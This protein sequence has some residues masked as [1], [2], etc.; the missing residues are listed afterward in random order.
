MYSYVK[1]MCQ[2]CPGCALAKPTCGKSSELIYNFPI[3][4]PFFI[5]FFV[6]YSAGK[7][8]SF[9]GFECYLIGCCGMSSFACMEPITRASAT[10][11]ASAIM[12]ILL[13][14]GFCHTIVLDKDSKFFGVCREAIDLLKN[15]CHILS[16]ANHN[17]MI[18]ERINR[19][20]TKG[21]KIMCN[22]RDSVR[23][24]LKAILL[25]LYAW[26]SCPVP[27][28]NIS[29]SLVAV[30]REFAF[31]INFS[32]GKHWEITSS[33]STIVLYSKELTTRQSACRQVAE[34]LVH[35]QRSYHCELINARRPDPCIYS[36]SNIVF[37]RH[38]VKSDAA[39]GHVDKLQYAFTGPW[40]I[41]AILPGASYELEHC[42]KPSKKEKKHASDLSP[43]PSELIPFQPVD[44]ADT[45]YGQLHKLISANPFK[46]G[47]IARFSPIQP[48]KVAKHILAQTD[49][50]TAFHWPS[51]SELNDDIALFPWAHDAE[52]EC[53]MSGDS[54]SKLP[55]LTTGPPPAAP[56]HSIPSI[57][58]IHLLTAAIIKSTDHLF[59]SL[60][61]SAPMT[62]GNGVFLGLLSMILSQF[63]LLA[64]WMDVS[65]LIFTS[66]IL[67][68]GTTMQSTS[69]I[70]SNST[71]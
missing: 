7:H 57:P 25:L 33:P 14:Y 9:E 40:H 3:E 65:F 52:Y 34:L 70:G 8:A 4:A 50:C 27:G 20:L 48:F 5:M 62:H 44:G 26:N 29:R 54:I 1:R 60:T 38:A 17:P 11:F 28:T 67:A 56:N 43:Y 45:Q 19:Y 69:V 53:Y 12:R 15:N 16:N 30:G 55:V 47:G 68:I 61:I 64:H 13:R 37:A 71:V 31:P 22:E 42:D 21:L 32:S 2:A 35:K 39:R 46:E 41:S 66:A 6:S 18:V 51:L 63:T 59:S 49:Q 24:A 23:V 58:A 36:L 10:T